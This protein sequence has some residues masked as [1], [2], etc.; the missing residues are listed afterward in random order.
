MQNE[1][2]DVVVIGGGP[3]GML[4]AGRAAECGARV[5]LLEKN[6]ELG[7]KLLITGGGRCN[8]TNANPDTKAL[9]AHYGDAAK[10]LYSAFALYGVDDALSFFHTRGVPTK[11]ENAFR[12]FPVSDS[13]ASIRD[14]LTSYLSTTGVAIHYDAR[15]DGFIHSTNSI[16]SVR[17]TDGAIISGR[18][19]VLATGGRSRPETGSTGEGFSWLES[20]GHTV[21]LSGAS[22]VPV[23]LAE[24]WAKRLQGVALSDVKISVFHEG[25]RQAVRT[26]RVLFTHFGITGPVILNMSNEIGGL[27]PYGTVTLTI[28]LFPAL[29][30]TDLDKR[31]VD[32]CETNGKRSI[33]NMLTELVP[34][35]LA[36]TLSAL[37]G[38]PLDAPCHAML[39]SQRAALITHLKSLPLT[40][41]KLMGLDKAVVTSGGVALEEVD[42]RT[43]QSRLFPNLYLVG[44][45]LDIDRPTGGYS[46]QLC[47][48][49]GY[50]AG[51]SAANN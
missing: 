8:V 9:I 42:F 3:A 46:L 45:V 2:W 41:E 28:D 30:S 13:A 43:M 36:T 17:L 29:E 7:R 27:I 4:A 25:V 32:L 5:L 12:V 33:R 1:T 35:A 22:L 39:K 15:V 37:A 14:A 20:I 21:R 38:I 24:D 31:L 44:D 10:F 6:P 23:A 49:T 11:V 50:I 16:S 18:S 47:W 51:T 34:K 48:T 26:G 40:V 19:F